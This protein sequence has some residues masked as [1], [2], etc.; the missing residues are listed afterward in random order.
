[1]KRIAVLLVLMLVSVAGYAQDATSKSKAEIKAEIKAQRKVEKVEQK[2]VQD[3]IFQAQQAEYA[4]IRRER[5]MKEG[6]TALVAKTPFESKKEILDLLVHSMI[7]NGITPASIDKDYYI[8]RTGKRS[9]GSATY[10]TTYTI[11]LDGG[12]VCVRAASIAEG[13]IGVSFGFANNAR[14]IVM[15]IEYNSNAVRGSAVDKAWREME[16]FLL[17]IPYS[18]VQ[19]IKGE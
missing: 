2:R 8:I 14:T 10:E 16:A 3:S 9:A 5:E 6:A 12:K 7:T 17:A 11:F 4:R 15:P 13:S 19:Y 1:M 18:N